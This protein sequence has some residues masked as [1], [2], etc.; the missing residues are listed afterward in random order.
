MPSKPPIGKSTASLASCGNTLKQPGFCPKPGCCALVE[1]PNPYLLAPKPLLTLGQP[2]RD[3][4]RLAGIGAL[5]QFGHQ[6]VD[7]LRRE[8]AVVIEVG[9]QQWRVVAV[10][11]ALDA[12]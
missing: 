11:Q 1:V 12:L 5:A 6:G 10:G 2:A 4:Q 8:V 3:A 7:F 9:L